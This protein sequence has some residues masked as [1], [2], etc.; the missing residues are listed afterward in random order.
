MG[1][2]AGND[3]APSASQTT[4]QTS[5]PTKPYVYIYVSYI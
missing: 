5:T 1:L 2:N 4:M 3:P